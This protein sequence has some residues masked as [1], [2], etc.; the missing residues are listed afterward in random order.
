MTTDQPAPADTVGTH[1]R[2]VG[3]PSATDP[4]MGASIQV[5]D[6]TLSGDDKW[7]PIGSI[8]RETDGTYTVFTVDGWVGQRGPDPTALVQ[9]KVQKWV[10]RMKQH[11][12]G[13]Y[14]ADGT[15]VQGNAR[16]AALK[17]EGQ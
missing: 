14:V 13:V 7:L 3:S 5:Y 15:V 4:T 17:R 6:D 2:L 11:D 1:Y 9:A 10:E 12:S 8:F 16:V